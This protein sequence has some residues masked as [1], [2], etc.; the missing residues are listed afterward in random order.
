MSFIFIFF[1]ILQ[2]F[3]STFIYFSLNPIHSILLLILLFFE[4]AI[5]LSLFNLEFLSI[6]FILIY[7]G[8]IAILFLFVIMLLQLKLNDLETLF[9]LPISISINIS[10]LIFC[11]SDIVSFTFNDSFLYSIE[12]YFNELFVI[13][14]YLFNISFLCLLLAGII[15]L[16]A[17]IGSIIISIDFSKVK[18]KIMYKKLIKKSKIF[19]YF[20]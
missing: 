1:I 7:V 6:L 2:V 8:A 9:F 18:Y 12:E 17:L 3:T 10:I 4:S 16:L 20:N 11:F 13:S 5:I 14:Q 15:L 19:S